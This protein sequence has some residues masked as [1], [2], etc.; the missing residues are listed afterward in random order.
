MSFQKESKII[1]E[2]FEWVPEPKEPSIDP[3]LLINQPL[4]KLFPVEIVNREAPN[5]T[6]LPSKSGKNEEPQNRCPKRAA[7]LDAD[8]LRQLRDVL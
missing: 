6:D 2:T 4:S 1:I 8:T 7:A 5:A 3:R